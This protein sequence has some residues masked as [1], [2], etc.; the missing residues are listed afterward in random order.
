MLCGFRALKDYRIKEENVKE[1]SEML[2]AKEYE[3]AVSVKKLKEENSLLKFKLAKAKE[4]T[5]KSYAKE[6]AKSE[7]GCIWTFENDLE[8]DEPRILMNSVIAEGKNVCGVFQTTG[9][10]EYR[11]VIG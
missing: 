11:Y 2:C 8:G 5:I 4:A 7:N 3:T 9:E 10:N 1:I 6:I